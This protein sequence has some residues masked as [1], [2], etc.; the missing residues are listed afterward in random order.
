M[1]DTTHLIGN[2]AYPNIVGDYEKTFAALRKLPVDIFIG[3]HPTYYG[4]GEKAA[5]L[6]ANPAGPNPFI[7]P[8][9]YKEYVDVSEQRFRAALAKENAAR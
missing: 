3:A 1:L 4:G 2:T 6:K 8:G 5:K 9:G 7:D